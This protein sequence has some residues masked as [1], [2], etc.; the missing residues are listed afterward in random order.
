MK[1]VLNSIPAL[2]EQKLVQSDKFLF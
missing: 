1:D 2:I